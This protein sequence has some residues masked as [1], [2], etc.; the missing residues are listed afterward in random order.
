MGQ[1]ISFKEKDI[2]KIEANF[3]KYGFLPLETSPMEIS[4]NIGSFLADDEC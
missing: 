2:K 4:E 3:I 1:R